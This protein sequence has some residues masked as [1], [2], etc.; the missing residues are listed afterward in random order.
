MR[1]GYILLAMF[2]GLPHTGCTGSKKKSGI[3]I[4]SYKLSKSGKKKKRRKGNFYWHDGQGG[5]WRYFPNAMTW[6]DGHDTCRALSKA[7]K[8]RW[9]LPNPDELGEARKQGITSSK[10]KGFGWIYLG[11]SWTV[12][13]ESGRDQRHATYINMDQ[14]G[15]YHTTLDHR[16][17]VVCVTTNNP[18]YKNIWIDKKTSMVWRYHP[19]A[20]S[21]YSGE[22]ICKN[23]GNRERLPWRMPTRDE[24]RQAV[25]DGIQSTRNLAFGREYISLAWSHQVEPTYPKEAYAVDLRNNQQFLFQKNKSMA[26]LCVRPL[27]H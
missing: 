20:S 8:R 22:S 18:K 3:E 25:D 6:E 5:M 14:G 26:V 19:R 10:N 11:N 4:K 21:W 15:T 9:R 12:N 27:A 1:Y 7:T 16:F 23:L 24:L 13:V 2:F 17:T